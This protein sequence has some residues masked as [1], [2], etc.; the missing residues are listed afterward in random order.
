MKRAAGCVYRGKG[1]LIIP[2]VIHPKTFSTVQFHLVMFPVLLWQ[3]VTKCD[4]AVHNQFKVWSCDIS[5]LVANLCPGTLELQCIKQRTNKT[6]LCL[7]G[8]ILN[9]GYILLLRTV[10]NKCVSQIMHRMGYLLQF[11]ASSYLHVFSP[12]FSSVSK[13]QVS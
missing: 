10:L 11:A 5:N 13:E 8:V 3:I 7:L 4:K 1:G 12:Y 2:D 6:E 9:W